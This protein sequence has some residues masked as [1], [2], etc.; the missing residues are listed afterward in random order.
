MS[1]ARRA[2]RRRRTAGRTLAQTVAVVVVVAALAGL[3]LGVVRLSGRDSGDQAGDGPST[4]ASPSATSLS[5]FDAGSVSVG[6]ADFCARVA[7]GAVEDALGAA[8][9]KE[10]TWKNGDRARVAPGE[11]DVVHEYGCSWTAPGGATAQA[12]VFAPPVARSDAAGLVRET[13]R[14]DGCRR[15]PAAPAF[16]TPSA[17]VRCR[18]SQ[19]VTTSF[20][21]LFGDAWLSCSVAGGDVQRAGRWCVSVAQAAGS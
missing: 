21:G 2:Q 7:P 6:R 10:T 19:G 15:L 20:H 4:P 5:D 18:T 17:A 16:G 8:S 11:R 13:A 9:T 14:A 12:W 1:G 3:V